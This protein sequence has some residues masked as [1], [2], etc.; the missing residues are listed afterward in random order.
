MWD[1]E[2]VKRPFIHK[3][4]TKRFY[5]IYDVNT[6]EFL[7]VDE[8]IYNIIDYIYS[9]SPDEIITKF[10]SK[11]SQESIILSINKIKRAIKEENIFLP[12][13]PEYLKFYNNSEIREKLRNNLNEI[14]LNITEKCNMR[15]KY[16]VYSGHYFFERTHSNRDMSE[17]VALKAIDFFFS[18][19]RNSRNIG[20]GFYGGEPLL[21]FNLIKKCVKYAKVK[22]KYNKKVDFT[23]TTN[24]TLLNDEIIDFLINHRVGL[25]IS[26][27]GPKKLHDRY[28]VFQ[29]GRGSF[30]LI[31]R[32]IL[33]IK[34]RNVDYYN[35]MVTFNMVLAPPYDLLKIE[36]W[37]NECKDLFNR[38]KP[39]VNLVLPFNNDFFKKNKLNSKENIRAFSFQEEKLLENYINCISK[40]KRASGFIH[41][42]FDSDFKNIHGRRLYSKFD[43]GYTVNHLCI[44]GMTKLLVNI[45]GKF[46]FCPNI[47]SNMDIGDV[48]S[49]FDFDK[50]NYIITQFLEISQEDCVKCWAIRLCNHSCY[51]VAAKGENFS[52]QQKRRA[53]KSIKR[54][55]ERALIVYN[56]ILEEH[57]ETF[58]WL[59]FEKS[60]V[61]F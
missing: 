59:I 23:I 13:R 32:N 22:N 11:Y 48:G 40:G 1:E 58:D 61:K 24:G 31:V 7:R 50:I 14:I 60:N 19:N 46:Y 10:S 16:C 56:E 43:K 51:H 52:L 45:K 39:L 35:T 29:N 12:T 53:C 5:Y 57:P 15:C 25:A 21:N 41:S 37:F 9:K 2:R 55:L 44:P 49:G 33:K 26:L 54:E 34:R 42:L 20:I 47:S 27:D 38:K 6:N 4:R 8:I 30:E 28:R 18:H 3:F 36:K 17:G